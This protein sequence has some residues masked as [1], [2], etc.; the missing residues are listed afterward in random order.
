[1]PTLFFLPWIQCS[2]PLELGQVSLQPFVRGKRPGGL[3][4]IAQDCFDGVL[5]RYGDVSYGL[6]GERTKTI[7]SA[8]VLWWDGDCIDTSLSQQIIENRFTQ[9]QF[10]LFSMMA[11]RRYTSGRYYNSDTL[12]AVAQP[13]DVS[14][15]GRLSIQSRMRYGTCNNMISSSGNSPIFIRPAHV[16]AN[17]R[18]S[19][20]NAL[21]KALVDLPDE[22]MQTQLAE[23]IQFY[24]LANS[25]SQ[26]F[27]PASEIVYLRS[28]FE[29]VLGASHETS[30]LREKFEDHF[31]S[32]LPTAAWA[33]GELTENVWRSR[34]P[35][36]VKRP[37]DAWVQDFC[38]ARNSSAHGTTGAQKHGP[39]IWH[40]HNH[41]MFGSWLFP[42][43]VKGVLAARGEYTLSNRD[44]DLRLG[45][46]A[47]FARDIL[48]QV[49]F[50]K[51]YWNEIEDDLELADL[52][53]RMYPSEE[54]S[55][56]AL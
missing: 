38:A 11:E 49:S 31:R 15:P 23:A 25:D 14:S 26:N 17:P 29:T 7:K 13:F 19:I 8:T 37:L 33:D 27:R 24:L 28:A 6:N 10:L 41:L 46:E 40:I 32:V 55:D 51:T 4:G 54:S 9:I 30:S 39:T 50:Q 20:D 12:T 42:L 43:V 52:A 2:E 18:I 16:E 47:F 5:G 3:G 34:H 1:M 56:A 48:K 36:N 45:F 21:F 53:R 44:K 35:K 22:G